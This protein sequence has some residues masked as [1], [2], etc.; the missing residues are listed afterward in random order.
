MPR[1]LHRE[2]P[3]H[4]EGDVPTLDH[5]LALPRRQGD[6]VFGLDADLIGRALH[7]DVLIRPQLL[8]VRVRPQAQRPIGRDALDAA[9]VRVQAA[10]LPT[11][12]AHGVGAGEVQIALQ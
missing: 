9:T 11:H 10:G 4:R 7:R 6:A 8:A 1:P 12:A 2:L 5:D 3:R